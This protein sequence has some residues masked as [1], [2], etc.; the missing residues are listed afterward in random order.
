MDWADEIAMETVR[1]E[2]GEG[3]YSVE[4]DMFASALRKAKADGMREAA[5]F[6]AGGS[7][8]H[9]KAPG[10][11]WADQVCPKLNARASQIERGEI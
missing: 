10:K 6:I 11:I 8:L 4:I 3:T 2:I 7:F 1:R 5:D 9:D